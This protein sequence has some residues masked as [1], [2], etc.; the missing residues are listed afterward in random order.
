MIVAQL[1]VHILVSTSM[2]VGFVQFREFN[3]YIS[4]YSRNEFE[5]LLLTLSLTAML[6]F[7]SLFFYCF[8]FVFGDF[9]FVLLGSLTI[10]FD[11]KELIGF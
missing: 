10:P 9:S 3:K 1:K 6:F 5:S 7:C 2:F 11:V 8:S 4:Y